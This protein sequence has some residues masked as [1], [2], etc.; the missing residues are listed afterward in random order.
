M[1]CR[2]SARSTDLN[3]IS[4]RPDMPGPLENQFLLGAKG[5]FSAA[6]PSAPRFSVFLLIFVAAGLRPP[7]GRPAAG[8]KVVP[9]KGIAAMVGAQDQHSWAREK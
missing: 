8:R 1:Q 3:Q 6:A 7:S 5:V 9:D 2:A 4:I